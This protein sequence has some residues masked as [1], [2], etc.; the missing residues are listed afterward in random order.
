MISMA[1]QCFAQNNELNQRDNQG[2]KHGE[3]TKKYDNGQAIYI[4]EFEHGKPVGTFK[5]FYPDGTLKAV[6]NYK[7]PQKVFTEL[8][9]KKGTKQAEGIYYN[10]KKDSTWKL[11]DTKG[12]LVS[13]ESYDKGV[14][15]GKSVKFYP[16]GDTSQVMRWKSGKKHGVFKQFFENGNIKMQGRYINGLLD[17]Y[18][19][20][21]YPNG[22]RKVVGRYKDNLREDKW[23]Y[24]NNQGDTAHIRNYKKGIPEN[25][26]SLERLETKEIL[27]LEKN[28]GKFGDP[29]D[30]FYNNSR[31]K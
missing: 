4:G 30:Q 27:E 2:R 14:R 9:N 10:R 6:M 31:R 17:G 7:T 29:R 21:F 5:R 20:F 11:Y 13:I 16:D 8:F 25:Q 23:V 15:E 22:Y 26:D 12:N 1:D 28:K 3:W 19:T 24:Y 18:L